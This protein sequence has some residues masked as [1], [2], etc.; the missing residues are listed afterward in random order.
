MMTAITRWVL[1]HKRIV[2]AVWILVT[3]VGIATVGQATKVFSNEFSVPGREA[4]ETNVA[5]AHLYHQG[6]RN[7]PIVPVVT[8]APGTPVSSAPVRAGLTQVEAQ[9]RAAIPGLRAASFASTGSG[10]SSRPTAGQPS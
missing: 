8:L 5:I 9:L 10:H 3:V 2:A 6:G 1:A 4:Y 7:A